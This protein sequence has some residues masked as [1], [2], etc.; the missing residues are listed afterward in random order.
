MQI[1]IGKY[2]V[3]KTWKYLLPCLRTY[4]PTFIAKYNSLFKLAV[5]VHDG[6]MDG[7][8]F[9][10]KK[11][12]YVL[13]DKKYRPKIALNVMQWF[14]YQ[15]FVL[16]DYAFD[17]LEEGRKHM[18]VIEVP[19]KYHDA[20][21]EFIKGNYSRMYSDKDIEELFPNPTSDERSVLKRTDIAYT[22]FIKK[23]KMNFGTDVNK[24]DLVGAELD[25]PIEKT[26]EVFNYREELVS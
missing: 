19:E 3:N 7:T 22:K 14:R 2:Y 13:I 21:D 1:E 5:G 15:S 9:E 10:N 16:T 24:S 18:F 25:F 8:E 26:K 4:G 23:V 11:V 20:Y 12:I 6:L 17:D